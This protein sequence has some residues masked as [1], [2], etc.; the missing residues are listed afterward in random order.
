MFVRKKIRHRQNLAYSL[1]IPPFI[2]KFVYFYIYLLNEPHNG[3]ADSRGF[4]PYFFYI[5]IAYSLGLGSSSSLTEQPHS[6]P[7]SFPLFGEDRDIETPTAN[8]PTPPV[9]KRE[10]VL[11]DVTILRPP[12]PTHSRVGVKNLS[13]GQNPLSLSQFTSTM[14]SPLLSPYPFHP[15]GHRTHNYLLTKLLTIPP[16]FSPPLHSVSLRYPHN[17]TRGKIP[18]SPPPP[19]PPCDAACNEIPPLPTSSPFSASVP[20]PQLPSTPPP[21]ALHAKPHR[22]SCLPLS[23]LPSPPPPSPLSSSL[24]CFLIFLH[25]ALRLQM[26][27]HVH[28]CITHPPPPRALHLQR[29]T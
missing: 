12:H 22:L 28:A 4:L 20:P 23:L 15:F 24:C 29:E 17:P 2:Y 9:W 8:Q 19:S 13:D 25:H 14:S 1:L 16:S 5:S 3:F 18:P 6:L 27:P 7:S 26:P 10:F 21:P 11:H